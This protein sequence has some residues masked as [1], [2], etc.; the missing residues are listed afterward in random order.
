[1]IPK[2]VIG[3]EQSAEGV[4]GEWVQSFSESI[5][6]TVLFTSTDISLEETVTGSMSSQENLKN[7]VCICFQEIVI[8][9]NECPAITVTN[10]NHSIIL[11]LKGHLCDEISRM[12]F[13]LDQAGAELWVFW[14]F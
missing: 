2:V 3:A 8:D 1:M 11:T 4:E 5:P 14:D 7:V 6:N 13:G 10:I 12:L 9:C